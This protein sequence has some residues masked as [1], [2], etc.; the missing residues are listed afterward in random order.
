[1]Y[2]KTA[3]PVCKSL[4]HLPIEYL[5]PALL[6]SVCFYSLGPW[7]DFLQLPLSE[8]KS[9]YQNQLQIW[10]PQLI[11][12]GTL[13]ICDKIIL[14]NCGFN[15]IQCTVEPLITR[16]PLTM[17][18]PILGLSHFSHVSGLCISYDSW[19]YLSCLIIRFCLSPKGTLNRGSTVVRS[20]EKLSH[21]S[22]CHIHPGLSLSSAPA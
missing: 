21:I 2:P 7:L 4:V 5:N 22:W 17:S 11:F 16:P 12:H 14:T 9:A 8:F 20:C 10:K 13:C 1:M 6:F 15:R 3:L 19:L 18:L